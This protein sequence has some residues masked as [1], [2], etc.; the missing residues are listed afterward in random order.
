MSETLLFV[1][2]TLRKGGPNHALL[3]RARCLGPATTAEDRRRFLPGAG[4]V[5]AFEAAWLDRVR[6]ARLAVYDMP[7]ETFEEA[8]MYDYE[9]DEAEAGIARLL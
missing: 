9:V 5:V 4:R 2:G 8:L 7:R 1:Y 3:A 6:T